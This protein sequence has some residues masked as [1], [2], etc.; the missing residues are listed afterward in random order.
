LSLSFNQQL[1]C[2]FHVFATRAKLFGINIHNNDI[3]IF[4]LRQY[5]LFIFLIQFSRIQFLHTIMADTVTKASQ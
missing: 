2:L 4:L 5:L 3:S 1:V